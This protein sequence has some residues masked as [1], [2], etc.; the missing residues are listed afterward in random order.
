MAAAALSQELTTGWTFRQTDGD[1]EWLSVARVPTNVHLDLLDHKQQVSTTAS[2][3]INK[4]S[5]DQSRIEDPFLGFNELKCEWVGTKPWSYKVTLQTVPAATTGT[6]HVLAFDGLDTYATVKLDGKVILESDNMFIEHRVD[7]TDKLLDGKDSVLEIDFKPALAEAQKVKGAHP[8]HKWVG[9]N[10][11]M[12]RLAVRKA[13]YHL[14]SGWDW[15]PILTTCGPWKAVRLETYHAQVEDLRVDYEVNDSFT[16]VTGKITATVE[17]SSGKQV[18]FSASFGDKGVFKGT[19]EVGSDGK[20]AVEFHV[21]EPK[22][23]YPHGYGEQ[24]L[25]TVTATVTTGEHDLHSLSKRTGFR[26]GELIQQPDDIGKTFFFRFNGIDVFCGGS[27][28]I[29]ADSFTPRISDERYRKW[30]EMMVD[31]YQIMIR[32]WG[33]GIWEADIF[34]DLC[35]ELGVLV[36]QDFM[37][38]CGNYPAFPAILKSIEKE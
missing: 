7:I 5:N 4:A 37:F 23:W 26:R 1:D 20:A 29:P 11:D 16:K 12:A 34:Y 24:P 15:G 32:V 10:G 19:T 3:A 17:G 31:G 8:E 28:W 13:Q 9:F 14:G 36:W 27:D 25:Y 6:K 22:L 35:D 2:S 21:N 38:G 33:G 18:N 30:L